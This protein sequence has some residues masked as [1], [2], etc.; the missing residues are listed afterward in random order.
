[1]IRNAQSTGTRGRQPTDS[2]AAVQTCPTMTVL[3]GMAPGRSTGA[4]EGAWTAR[5]HDGSKRRL[6]HP[7]GHDQTNG[8]EP[9]AC[10][11]DLFT[12]LAAAHLDKVV[13]ALMP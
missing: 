10:L 11:R 9:H 8:V 7:V 13:D 4:G 3:C 6:N 12:R 1:M 2:D 5:K